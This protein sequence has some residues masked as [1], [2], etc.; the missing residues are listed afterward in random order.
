MV[1]VEASASQRKELAEATLAGSLLADVDE[2][3][4]VDLWSWSRLRMESSAAAIMWRGMLGGRVRFGSRMGAARLG[5][6]VS[7]AVIVALCRP[8]TWAD[9]VTWPVWPV[10][11]R[12][13]IEVIKG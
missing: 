9:A 8:V 1:R 13:R 3:D 10:A 12:V 7:D 6:A 11:R 4:G 5:Q 2:R